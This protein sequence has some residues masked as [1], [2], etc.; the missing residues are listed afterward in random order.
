MS[1]S[2]DSA[3]RTAGARMQLGVGLLLALVLLGI[4]N[5]LAYRHYRRF[6]WTEQRSFTLSDRTRQ[7]L[8]RLDRDVTDRKSV[9]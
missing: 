8:R 4:C 9:V 2:F 5:Y 6:D 1:E 7:V 3:R